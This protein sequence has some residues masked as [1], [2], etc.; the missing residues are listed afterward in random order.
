MILD[1]SFHDDTLRLINIY[2][3]VPPKGHA[4][5]HIFTLDLDP[6]VPTFVAGDFN[7]HGPEWSLPGATTSP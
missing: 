4:L 6:V 2:H 1:I 7:T 3:H 5:S